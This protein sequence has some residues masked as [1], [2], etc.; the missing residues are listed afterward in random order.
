VSVG[1][2][3][4]RGESVACQLRERTLGVQ[5]LH[6]TLKVLARPFQTGRVLLAVMQYCNDLVRGSCLGGG[7]APPSPPQG[8]RAGQHGVES[9]RWHADCGSCCCWY[10]EESKNASL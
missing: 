2:A 1:A 5:G 8:G 4:L 10:V 3:G 7:Y 6:L 9:G